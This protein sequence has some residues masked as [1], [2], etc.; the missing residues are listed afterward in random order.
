MRP[1]E[2]V[3]ETSLCRIQYDAPRVLTTRLLAAVSDSYLV[4][5]PGSESDLAHAGS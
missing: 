4:D 3:D 5:N 2:L 1:S